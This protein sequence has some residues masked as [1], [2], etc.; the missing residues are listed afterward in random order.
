MEMRA[1]WQ[2]MR[3]ILFWVAVVKTLA[4]VR[5]HACRGA[6]S[7]VSIL[8]TFKH[9]LRAIFPCPTVKVATTPSLSWIMPSPALSL[10]FSTCKMR[11]VDLLAL[12]TPSA[13]GWFFSPVSASP[14][15]GMSEAPSRGGYWPCILGL[16]AGFC[17]ASEG[18]CLCVHVRVSVPVYWEWLHS[19]CVTGS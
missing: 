12:K 14:S 1:L 18:V 7:L 4:R 17:L 10:S 2:V 9:S 15:A 6:S 19:G 16:G 5:W 13:W 11:Q 8:L 3:K